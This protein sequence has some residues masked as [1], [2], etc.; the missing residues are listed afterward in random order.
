MDIYGI[1][2]QAHG[3]LAEWLQFG[4]RSLGA[5]NRNVSGVGAPER[6]S[7]H[8]EEYHRIYETVLS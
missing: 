1:T 5:L 2:V 3:A 8:D 6:R 4:W 7:R